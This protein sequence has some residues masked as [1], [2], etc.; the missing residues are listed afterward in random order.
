MRAGLGTASGLQKRKALKLT[1]ESAGRF[2]LGPCL[3]TESSVIGAVGALR[4]SCCTFWPRSALLRAP[5][6][7][8]LP[9]GVAV[10]PLLSENVVGFGCWV[11]RCRATF[12][13]LTLQPW[14]SA[15]LLRGHFRADT[16]TGEGVGARPAERLPAPSASARW[17]VVQVD[18]RCPVATVLLA[19]NLSC[20]FGCII[21]SS[22]RT[23]TRTGEQSAEDSRWCSGG[24]FR[25]WEKELAASFPFQLFFLLWTCN[26]LSSYW[27]SCSLP[28]TYT[29]LCEDNGSVPHFPVLKSD[30]IF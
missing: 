19:Q 5:L 4:E 2:L 25:Q 3:G 7:S 22:T 10:N 21:L 14:R 15:S 8:V 24:H 28:H 16:G 6:K 11:S 1:C 12:P 13:C 18:R 9:C 30:G 23:R 20:C 17:N 26:F 29:P 27:R